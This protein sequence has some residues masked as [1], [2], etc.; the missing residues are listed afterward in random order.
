MANYSAQD[1]ATL[2][3]AKDASDEAFHDA[4][5]VQARTDAQRQ[6]EANSRAH[7]A[8]RVFASEPCRT[9][10]AHMI[11]RQGQPSVVRECFVAMGAMLWQAGAVCSLGEGVLKVEEMTG[12]A[13]PLPVR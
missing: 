12:K 6:R 13:C 8:R 3:A 5:A 1:M 4:S 7:K 9:M 10:H 2:M 11:Q